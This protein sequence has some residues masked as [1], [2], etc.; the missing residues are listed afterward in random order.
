MLKNRLACSVLLIF[1]LSLFLK[2]QN[3]DYGKLSPFVRQTV[4]S[5]LCFADNAGNKKA[6]VNPHGSICAFV[7]VD[8]DGK[9]LLEAAHCRV[10]ANWGDIYIADIP[11]A[12]L[13]ELSN[14]SRVSR[15]EAG[16]S[17]SLCLDTVPVIIGADKVRYG[18]GLPQAYDGSGVVLGIMDV[19]FDVTHP[20]FFDTSLTHTRISR[21]WDQLSADSLSSSLYVGADYR[22]E[23]DILAYAHSRDG[24]IETHGTHTLGIASGTGFDS[25]YR[26]MAPAADLCLVSNAV[27]TDI[28]LIPE[29]QLYRYTTAT[30]AFG[31]KYIFDY[32][33]EVG[34][35]C[36]ISF[37][38]GSH[39]SLDGDQQLFYDVLS[40][41][42][43]PGR[44][45]VASAGNEGYF[46]TYLH[47]PVGVERDGMFV[48]SVNSDEGSFS[49]KSSSP[50]DISLCLYSSEGKYDR[51]VP[52]SVVTSAEDSLYTDSVASLERKIVYRI[53]AYRS[54]AN[55]EETVYDVVMNASGGNV[56]LSSLAFSFINKE[57]DVEAFS[58]GLVFTS[59]DMDPSLSGGEEK[60]CVMSPSA[61][62]SVICVGATAY[63]D[64]YI[65]VN[66]KRHEANFGKLGG[67]SGF[68]SVG[69]TRYGLTKPDVVAPGADV[70]S[71]MSSFYPEGSPDGDYMSGV[72]S[73][74]QYGGRRYP[75]GVLSGTSQSAPVV[76]GTVALWLQAN[77]NLSPHDIL[78]VF[79]STCK[80]S[81]SL[82]P[83]EKDNHWGYG[84]IDAYSGLLNVLKLDGIKGIS[85]NCPSSVSMSYANGK[86]IFRLSG[87]AE[88]SSHE[89]LCVYSLSGTVV[90]DIAMHFENGESA[91]SLSDLPGG[92]YL[93]QLTSPSPGLAGSFLVRI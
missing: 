45:L 11:F 67:V 40:R 79:S 72:C 78:D 75:W 71:S 12:S 70:Y 3:V 55:P 69:P 43:G 37:S 13:P 2:A 24:F 14:S 76:A 53:K 38:E 56:P 85:R 26:G 35:P 62:P 44:I 91:I 5:R 30:D 73:Y 58:N 6:I 27:N 42:T 36:V 17:N 59:N 80:R 48:Y 90:K 23:G 1:C 7:R 65:D 10:L 16:R 46:N 60:C 54:A 15:I 92:V 84:E 89:R 19:G 52:T 57:A 32:A 68:S 9:Q 63:R 83:G 77:P 18:S 31:F 66:G 61:A 22:T 28:P 29:N 86:V 47:K 64:T 20:N 21:F 34:K 25:V 87:D 41:M 33:D 88:T 93:L 50:F 81:G 74:S 39:E 51:I 8:G 49:V 82:N 4:S